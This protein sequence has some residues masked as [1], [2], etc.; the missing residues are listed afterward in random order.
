MTSTSETLT[1]PAP[2]VRHVRHGL[3]GGLSGVAERLGISASEMWSL[4]EKEPDVPMSASY[5]GALRH[6]DNI[7]ALLD[8]VG[9]ESQAGDKAVVIDLNEHTDALYGAA[10]FE[11]E[12]LRDNILPKEPTRA[13]WDMYFQLRD[14][15][16]TLDGRI[17]VTA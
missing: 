9:W 2:L 4:S 11:A 3:H 8:L 1:L 7:R 6:L 15:V 12:D 17:A 13:G 10:S 5:Q 16:E 14:L